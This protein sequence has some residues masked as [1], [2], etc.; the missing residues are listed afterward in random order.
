MLALAIATAVAPAVAQ[1]RRPGQDLGYDPAPWQAFNTDYSGRFTFVRLMVRAFSGGRGFR[2]RNPPWAHD[3]PTAETN[4]GKILNELTTM[5]PYLDGGNVLA[6]DDP[7]LFKYP[8]AYLSEPGYWTMSEGEAAN[9]RDYLLKGGFLILDDFAGPEQWYYTQV[10]LQQLLPDHSVIRLDE[11]HPIFDS[12]FHIEQ[13]EMP[14]PNYGVIASYYAIFRN[15][16]PA[17]RML[18]MINRDNDIG[19]YWEWSDR[20]YV[21]IELSNEAYKLG[22]N[23]VVYALT[24]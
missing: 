2:Q 22:V 17:D 24:H 8:I 20:G 5:R 3:Y 1:E 12:F 16:D 13:I 15:N 4:F 21:P 19:D 9:L 10:A 7:E 18:V 11:T 6:M 23:Y 14:H